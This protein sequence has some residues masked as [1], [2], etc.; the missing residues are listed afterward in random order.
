MGRRASLKVTN[1]LRFSAA[2]PPGRPVEGPGKEPL[3]PSCPEGACL[4]W[5]WP[6]APLPC[7]ISELMKWSLPRGQNSPLRGQKRSSH[8]GS[9]WWGGR[10]LSIYFRGSYF[11]WHVLP[12]SVSRSQGPTSPW[13]WLSL[14]GAWDTPEHSGVLARLAR[15]Q[16]T[17]DHVGDWFGLSQWRTMASPALLGPES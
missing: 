17:A 5:G 6:W 4:Q 15:S 1:R 9:R 7:A 14:G 12:I 16:G 10:Q 11:F 13:T 2:S 3:V 8:P